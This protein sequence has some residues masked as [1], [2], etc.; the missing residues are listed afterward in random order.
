MAKK[1][2]IIASLIIAAF[3]AN[4]QSLSLTH[5]GI[6]LEPNAQFTTHGEANDDE[7]IN[8]LDVTNNSSSSMEVLVKKIE[9]YLVDSSENTFCWA[10][11]CFAP[12]V[13][14][15]PYTV[16]IPA[17]GT[18]IDG[19]QGHYNP[20]SHPGESSVS[21]V[22]F[23]EANPNDSVMVTVI[24]T[25]LET[26]IGDNYSSDYTFSK[27]YP[28]PATGVVKFDYN[29]PDH[30]DVSVKI[31]SLIGSQVGEAKISAANGTLSFNTGNLE[32]GFYFYSLFTGSEK[33]E[34]GK[35]IINH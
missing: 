1:L 33:M 32:D 7:M 28:N 10:G 12:F 34:S 8:H 9:N 23:D 18:E 22:F 29:L 5:D 4:A 26:G 6:V 3:V 25:T 20:W 27:P 14:V 19:F 35:F 17:G 21:Y 24:Y 16:T 2:F 13:Y 31:Y 30:Q 15:S 11:L